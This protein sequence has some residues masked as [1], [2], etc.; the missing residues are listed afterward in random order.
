MREPDAW[1]DHVPVISRSYCKNLG[2]YWDWHK[3]QLDEALKEVSHR[4]G[5]AMGTIP[6]TG[7]YLMAARNKQKYKNG[8]PEDLVT[9]VALFE[10][11]YS[12]SHFPKTARGSN[13]RAWRSRSPAFGC[14]GFFGK[15]VRFA[16]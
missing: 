9:A 8:Q 13:R 15:S 16:L 1:W 10:D 4:C 2:E 11:E 3:Q 7:F 6:P 5:E 14:L 12:I